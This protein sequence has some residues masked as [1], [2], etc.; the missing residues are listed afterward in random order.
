MTPEVRSMID[1]RRS[2]EQRGHY[3]PLGRLVYLLTDHGRIEFPA[4]DGEWTG[5]DL[6]LTEM[7]YSQ[8]AADEGQ[9]GFLVLGQ[10][11]GLPALR[12]LTS[13]PC[14]KCR[15]ACDLCDGTGKKQCEGLDCGGRGWIRGAWLVC[16]GPGCTKETGNFNP[17]CKECGGAGQIREKAECPMCKGTKLMTCPRCRGTLKF[18]TGRTGGAIDYHAPE[19]RF[20]DGTG[21]QCAMQKQDVKIF[22]N[23][24]LVMPRTRQC[25]AKGFLVLGPIRA[26]A[27]SDYQTSDVRIFDVSPDSAGDLL[28]L[29]VP[30]GARQRPHKAYLVG[31]VVREREVRAAVPA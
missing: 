10:W 23:A 21:Y 4:Q 25:G 11:T 8:D 28:V 17:E 16:P 27:L 13:E 7:K 12:K 2:A 20:C 14:P 6:A 19:C 15:H 22:T 26:F 30:R 31:G 24:T 1:L 3:S 9:T 29:L 18:S 5:P